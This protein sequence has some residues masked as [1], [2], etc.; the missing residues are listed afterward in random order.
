MQP[1]EQLLCMYTLTHG[2]VRNSPESII[3]HFFVQ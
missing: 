1:V 2:C 3:D